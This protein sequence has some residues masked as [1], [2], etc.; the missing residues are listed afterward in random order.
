MK[1]RLIQPQDIK[2]KGMTCRA[3]IATILESALS[4]NVELDTCV[5]VKK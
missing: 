2:L 4:R 3:S 5:G 1:N